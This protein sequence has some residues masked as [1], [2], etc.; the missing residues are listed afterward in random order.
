MP[1]L[2]KR[3]G[4]A[5][6]RVGTFRADRLAARTATPS[7]RELQTPAAASQPLLFQ[8]LSRGLQGMAT[9]VLC[10]KSLGR[11][12]TK[13]CIFNSLS[14]IGKEFFGKSCQQFCMTNRIV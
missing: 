5:D 10:F 8:G 14:G 13:A 12:Q 11:I 7:A 2:G 4:S 9:W 6:R 3:L 1:R